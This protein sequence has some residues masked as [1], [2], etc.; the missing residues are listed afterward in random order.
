MLATA[1]QLT[2]RNSV[3][4]IV[5]PEPSET[6]VNTERVQ[7]MTDRALT[8]LDAGYPVHFSGPAGTG[9]TTLAFHVASQLGRPVMLIHGD[10]EFSASDLIGKD[11]G[12]R[13]S[14]LVDNFIHSVVKTEEEMRSLWVENCLTTAC[15]EGATLIYDEFT[16]SRPEANNALLAI[17]EEKI[18]TMP[19]VQRG[20][21]GYQMV[22]PNFRVLF[23]SNPEEY[24]GTHKTQ[25]ALLDR[26]ITMRIGHNDFETEVQITQKKGGAKRSD[27]E[28][29]VT[30]IRRL[31]ELSASEHRPTIRAGIAIAKIISR[32]NASAHAADKFFRVVCHDVLNMDANAVKEGVPAFS[33]KTVD[34]LIDEICGFAIL[35][36]F[37]EA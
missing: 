4:D 32:R 17:L 27:A 15:R 35:D 21:K 24:V 28:R 11:A 2:A 8:Y 20:G 34:E 10:D 14:K 16:R 9:K 3:S 23:T 18:M 30:L 26:M 33:P 36:I 1:P 7:E 29:I 13:R 25:D 19:S 22:H 31:R 12:Y 6:F 5:M 37:R